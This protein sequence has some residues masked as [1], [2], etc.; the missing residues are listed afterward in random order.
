[1]SISF[2]IIWMSCGNAAIF[3]A[4]RGWGYKCEKCGKEWSAQLSKVIGC[5]QKQADETCQNEF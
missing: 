4:H 3:Q 5:D 2:D 1:M